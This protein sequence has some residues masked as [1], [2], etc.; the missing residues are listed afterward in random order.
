MEIRRSGMGFTK[1]FSSIV[2]SS[3]WVEDHPTVRV[4]IGM[5]A[6][7]NAN[8][9]VEGSIPGLANVCRVTPSE[10]QK[11]LQILSQPDSFS[12]NPENEGRRIEPHPGGWRILNYL[13]YRD[14][15]Q[16]KDGSRADYYRRYRVQHRYVARNKR[17]LRDTQKQK[18][19]EEKKIYM[20]SPS[21]SAFE[22]FYSA[23]PKKK[24]RRN[25]ER[26]W[27]KL[28][29]TPEQVQA[30]MTALEKHKRSEDWRK[31]RGKFVPYPATWLNGHR[32]ED[33]LHE[34]KPSW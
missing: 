1:L 4:W 32:W 9:V 7:A 23:Y 25:A 13:N 10:C 14:R 29:L 3:I 5:L 18:T 34:A 20:R 21:D 6:L 22:Q 12:R 19:E 27:A 16:D 15:G 26:A 8:G 33:E 2:T 28:N 11:A 24:A 31:D 30:I 17:V